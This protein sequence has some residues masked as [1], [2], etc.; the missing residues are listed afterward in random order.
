MLDTLQSLAIILLIVWVGVH[1]YID[2]GKD[3]SGGNYAV[4]TV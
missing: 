3:G 1:K 4:Q 2:H